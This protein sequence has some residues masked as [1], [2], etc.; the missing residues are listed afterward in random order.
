[1]SRRALFIASAKTGPELKA[2]DEDCKKVYGVLTD[3]RFGAHDPT[4]SAPLI[5]GCASE[6]DLVFQLTKFFKASKPA[7]QR[8]VYFTGHGR[9]SG[10]EYGFVLNGGDDFL[11]FSAVVGLLKGKGP[12]K[13]VFILDTCHS[14]AADLGGIKN[15]DEL[16]MA[17]AAGSCVIASSRD[18][19]F[20]QEVPDLGS[21]FTHFL[22]ECITTG[23]GGRPT[24]EGLITIPDVVHYVQQ[25]LKERAA[26][27]QQLQTPRYSIRNAESLFWIARNI[28]GA[29][30]KP[31]PA[32]PSTSDDDR[33]RHPCVGATLADLDESLVRSYA[34]RYLGSDLGSLEELFGRLDLSFSA[35]DMQPNE[36]AVLSFGVRPERFFPNAMSMF[37]SGDRASSAF[38][39]HPVEGAL[40]RQLSELVQ[41]VSKSLKRTAHFRGEALREDETEI[42]SD[43]LREVVAN[44]I[45]HRDFEAS[46][47][48][49]VHIEDEYVEISNPGHF[50]KDHSW[51]ELLEHP[52]PSLTRNRRLAN[53]MQRF[54]AYEGVGRGFSVLRRYR[55]Q[56]GEG[57]VRFEQ[58]G[59]L[60]HCRLARPAS[61]SPDD[62]LSSARVRDHESTLRKY[63]SESVRAL[64]QMHAAFGET[65]RR[66]EE[67][68]LPPSTRTADGRLLSYQTL[69][70][71]VREPGADVTV[72]GPPGMGKTVLLRHIAID[73]TAAIESGKPARGEAR[74]NGA[75]SLGEV[76]LQRRVPV[77]V[78]LRSLRG[79][80]PLVAGIAQ[81]CGLDPEALECSLRSWSTLLLFDGLDEAPVTE[82]EAFFSRV[83]ALKETYP[84]V[85]L[86]VS[87]RTNSVSN[88]S[89]RQ[90]TQ[91][92]ISPLSNQSIE[93]YLSRR[94]PH[95]DRRAIDPI[96]KALSAGKLEILRSP[97]LLSMV[98]S[99]LDFSQ[100]VPTDLNV[101]ALVDA[102]IEAFVFRHD[103]SKPGFTRRTILDRRDTRSVLAA[104]ALRMVLRSA[105]TV[106]LEEFD[107][108]VGEGLR[109]TG[110]GT[111][112]IQKFS[113]REIAK[114]L[115]RYGLIAK[116]ANGSIAF[117]HRT[118]Q[119]HLAADFVSR[120]A[121]ATS[122]LA[123]LVLQVLSVGNN[124]ELAKGM[125]CG[126]TRTAL[127]GNALMGELRNA[128]SPLSGIGEVMSALEKHISSLPEE[129]DGLL[130]Q[131]LDGIGQSGT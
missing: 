75:D 74:Q 116:D 89:S 88:G 25:R 121:I 20:S 101:D 126:W 21:L 54:G 59:G 128:N 124:V 114:E 4:L 19:E 73:L 30:S 60:V 107:Q 111:S 17:A 36:A 70:E 69:L 76:E 117:I 80:L 3:K 106:S 113:V 92:E 43:V 15:T 82:Q 28:S 26:A 95:L 110:D 33:Q 24:S 44:A 65:G 123:K 35:S 84:N 29:T 40:V 97:L 67:L 8:I 64:T 39:T 52:G 109:L 66:L 108:L 23:N 13:T 115:L 90:T 120:S 127:Q 118:L 5:L 45:A 10:G 51:A 6:E 71:I 7:D 16:P 32:L 22:C 14:G 103:Q 49:H 68:F 98:P 83:H 37:S 2:G 72:T 94:A 63:V 100:S 85:G 131:L 41:L 9:V 47:R 62:L 12:G 55:E 57:A 122:P 81:V 50:P 34:K 96:L 18:I 53:H 104:V 1:M 79:D 99:L 42:P 38:T 46:G 48:V 112:Q 11:P 58:R 86:V 93:A 91:L 87:A 78:P 61:P 77:F 105:S 31:A 130:D 119:D 27:D 56:Q 102:A 125:V 129:R